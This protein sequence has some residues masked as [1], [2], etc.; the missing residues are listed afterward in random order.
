MYRF[1]TLFCLI[2]LLATG[3]STKP[4]NTPVQPK[5]VFVSGETQPG[6][7]SFFATVMDADGAI[8][9]DTIA[10]NQE[11]V[12]R[13]RTLSDS[14][15]QLNLF[16]K[17]W[18][19][20]AEFYLKNQD[21]INLMIW[22]DSIP[23]IRVSGDTVNTLLY[24]FINRH[25]S[26]LNELRLNIA[27]NGYS[28]MSPA[29]DSLRTAMIGHIKEFCQKHPTNPASSVVIREC[30]PLFK[31]EFEIE[32]MLNLL[33]SEGSPRL[34][35]NQIAEYIAVADTLTLNR[36]LPL[37]SCRNT[38]GKKVSLH[39][40]LKSYTLFTFWASWD[41]QSVEKVKSA[42]KLKETLRNSRFEI[43]NISL[44]NNDSIWEKALKDQKI[45]GRNFRL[46]LG[47]ADE[48]VGKFGIHTIPETIL[49]D[50]NMI[51]VQKNMPNEQLKKY[52]E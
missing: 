30:L 13:Y 6:P 31:N 39:E 2:G 27:A 9:F 42:M 47:F 10:V 5:Y 50:T 32:S 23:A 8:R 20:S 15:I 41:K 24:T 52:L 19:N 45:T 14:L 7:E 26:V 25:G 11:G 1:I 48:I 17:G 51:V 49:T 12:F 29:S 28:G 22:P 33:Q 44:D 35:R 34:I 37:V 40:T 16:Y 18:E 4:K 21:T 36:K 46:S 38:D 3:C 43:V